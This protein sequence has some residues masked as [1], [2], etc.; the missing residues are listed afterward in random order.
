MF[1]LER[2]LKHYTMK[3]NSLW[4]KNTKIRTDMFWLKL[5]KRRHGT[6]SR[7]QPHKI[8]SRHLL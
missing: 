5:D 8:L 1:Y 2:N 6:Q 7:H 4:K 3:Q